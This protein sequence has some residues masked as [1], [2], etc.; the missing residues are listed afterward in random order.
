MFYALSWWGRHAPPPLGRSEF[1]RASPHAAAITVASAPS[2]VPQRAVWRSSALRRGEKLPQ[3]GRAAHNSRVF[4]SLRPLVPACLLLAACGSSQYP[5][6]DDP[7]PPPERVAPSKAQPAGAAAP[8]AAP[9]TLPR[10]DVERV[11]DAGLGRFLAHV[12]IEPSLSAGKFV[13]WRIV[14]LSPP[15]LWSAVDLKPGDVVSRVNGMSIER[16]MDAFDAFQAVRQAPVLEVIYLRQNQPRT[17]RFTI[18]GAPSPALPKAAPAP[19]NSASAPAG[20]PG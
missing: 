15:E 8:A 7:L 10:S 4:T 6:L 1:G 11:V 20:K 14:G 2:S 13:G 19:V 12:A 18:V 9:G 5:T 16:E 3:L 17:L